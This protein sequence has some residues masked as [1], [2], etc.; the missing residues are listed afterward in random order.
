[1]ITNIQLM[2]WLA[3]GNGIA[4]NA[5]GS[6]CIPYLGSCSED[7]LDK[8][9]REAIRIRKSGKPIIVKSPT[10]LLYYWTHCCLWEA[11]S[12]SLLYIP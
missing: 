8:P 2:E 11:H 7:M 3:K 10:S 1:M 6:Q 12:I 9:I 4:K 5:G